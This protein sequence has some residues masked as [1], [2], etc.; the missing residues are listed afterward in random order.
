MPTPRPKDTPAVMP[1]RAH[2]AAL[3]AGCGIDL[4]RAAER[5]VGT[6]SC[7]LGKP[8]LLRRVGTVAEYL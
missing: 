2:F 1:K 7:C 4:L 3:P 8:P 5:P 6:R